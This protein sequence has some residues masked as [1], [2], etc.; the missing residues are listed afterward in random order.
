MAN[1]YYTPEDIEGLLARSPVASPPEQ[2]ALYNRSRY[3]F[4]NILASLEGLIT[5]Q[6]SYTKGDVV[7][8]SERALRTVIDVAISLYNT[9]PTLNAIIAAVETRGWSNLPASYIALAV[10]D[11]WF[12]IP[13][14]LG[15][16]TLSN[17]STFAGTWTPANGFSV[18]AGK[19]VY[20]HNAGPNTATQATGDFAVV[21][22]ASK[23]YKFDY[24]ISEASGD[25]LTHQINIGFPVSNTN[26]HY[27][28]G[29]WSTYFISAAVIA[30]FVIS[31]TS[32]AGAT[33]KVDDVQLTRLVPAFL[34]ATGNATV[35]NVEGK[36][37]IADFAIKA[38]RELR[39]GERAFY[40][41]NPVQ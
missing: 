7:L 40:G 24:T 16:E 1:S 10:L 23:W 26:L 32:N 12:S 31:A 34:D 38:V 41:A 13:T 36:Q 8:A 6:V 28:N 11:L 39:E 18:A 14:E 27:N 25:I 2:Y 4:A 30:N 5:Q 33:F 21:G 22:V 19:L 20:A 29:K 17:G 35:I 3:R 9:V 15:A 37:R